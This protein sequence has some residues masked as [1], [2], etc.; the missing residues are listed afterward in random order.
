MGFNCLKARAT[1]RRQFTFYQEVPRNSWYSFYWPRKDGR[2]SRPWS[3]PVVLNR[4]PLDWESSIW[5]TTRPLLR[6][7]WPSSSNKS[8][9][10][11][12]KRF[13]LGILLFHCAAKSGSFIT[14][15][16]NLAVSGWVGLALW[17][18]TLWWK[19]T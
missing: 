19:V 17:L 7:Q 9:I 10:Q 6:K 1:L 13:H 8:L 2:L 16:I 3:H 4:G 14:L 18:L 12:T 11:V 15:N 5:T